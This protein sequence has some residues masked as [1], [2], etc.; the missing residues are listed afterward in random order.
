MSSR[1]SVGTQLARERAGPRDE[2]RNLN[3]MRRRKRNL[4]QSEQELAQIAQR[5]IRPRAFDDR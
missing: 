4:I 1:T 2:R 3:T 5:R